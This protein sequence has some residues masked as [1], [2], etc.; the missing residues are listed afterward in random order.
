M[1]KNTLVKLQANYC[2]FFSIVIN[3]AVQ[4]IH[5]LDQAWER[6]F[7]VDL[8]LFE[9]FIFIYPFVYKI[10]SIKSV[11]KKNYFVEII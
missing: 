9:I 5:K 11:I 8:I 2:V 4:I 7:K 3:I 1:G 10:L 6:F